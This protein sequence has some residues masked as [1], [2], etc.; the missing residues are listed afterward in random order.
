[1]EPAGVDPPRRQRG[2]CRDFLDL[3]HPPAFREPPTIAKPQPFLPELL[4]D[5]TSGS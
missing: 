5:M 4:R 1:M 3:K 2:D